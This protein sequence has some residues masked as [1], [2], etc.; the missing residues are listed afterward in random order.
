[1]KALADKISPQDNIHSHL[2]AAQ[3]IKH[4]L[5]LKHTYG[6]RFRLLY[7]WYDVLGPAGYNHHKEIQKFTQIAKSD[8]IT[9]QF[10][11]YQRF[12]LSLK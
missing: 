5:A 1:M 6:K 8:G 7:L 4:I 11:S 2:H 9:V 10:C 12:L 3:L